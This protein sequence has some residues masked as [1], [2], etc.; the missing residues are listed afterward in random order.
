MK[1]MIWLCPMRVAYIMAKL[2]CGFMSFVFA[3]LFIVY[4]ACH[5]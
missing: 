3:S 1:P 5:L 4:L 2:A